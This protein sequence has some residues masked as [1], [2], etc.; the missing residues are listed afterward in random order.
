MGDRRGRVT[1]D[2]TPI[3]TVDIRSVGWAG[4]LRSGDP[5]LPAAG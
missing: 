2:V 3:N 1:L 5:I 4:R